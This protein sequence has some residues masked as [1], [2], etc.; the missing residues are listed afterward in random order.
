MGYSIE[1][2]D[3]YIS[4]IARDDDFT[5]DD[6]ASLWEDHRIKYVKGTITAAWIE[7]REGVSPLVHLM[8]EDDGQLLWRRGSNLVF[9]AGWIDD[10]LKTLR[11]VKKS[12]SN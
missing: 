10:Y 4:V 7:E 6:I 8:D 5:K 2:Y 11:A 9:S 1:K 3:D 12:L